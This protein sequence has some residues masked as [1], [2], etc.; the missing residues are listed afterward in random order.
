MEQIEKRFL[1]MPGALS[2]NASAGGNGFARGRGAEGA[3]KEAHFAD[4][5]LLYTDRLGGTYNVQ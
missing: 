4:A 1:G 3:E 5:P 2:K